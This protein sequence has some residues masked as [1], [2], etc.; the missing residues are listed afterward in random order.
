MKVFLSA[1]E[2]RALERL[3]CA[4]VPYRFLRGPVELNAFRRL[5]TRKKPLAR[6]VRS[7][8]FVGFVLEG[9]RTN[10]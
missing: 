2:E 1:D 9:G 6:F 4:P 5:T 3:R 7:G 8:M 10:G